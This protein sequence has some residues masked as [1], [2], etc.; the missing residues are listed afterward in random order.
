MWRPRGSGSQ[1][2][3]EFA[4]KRDLDRLMACRGLDALVVFGGTESNPIMF[5][6]TDGANISNGVYIH[7]KGKKPHLVH[8]PMER[9]N[10][11][12]S[13][14]EIS[15]YA[16]HGLAG[17]L[18]KEPDEVS[19]MASFYYSLLRTMGVQGKVS[20]YGRQ[21]LSRLLPVISRLQEI[22]RDIEVVPDTGRTVFDEARTTKS[23]EEIAK[24]RSIGARCE[25]AIARVVE[26]LRT[27][28]AEGRA[29]LDPAGERLTLGKIK[30]VLRDEL[31]SRSLLEATG[32]IV[33]MGAEAGVPHNHGTDSVEV[34]VES[35]IIMDVFPM[36][37]GGGYHFDITRTFC[38]GS[39]PPAVR[40]IYQDV[41]DVQ[42]D[43]IAALKVGE[44]GW[45]YQ[46]LACDIFEK[47]GYPTIRQN[48]KLTEGYVHNLGHGIGLE[49]HES[50][51]L[52]G[53]PTNTDV[54]V[55]GS[56]FTIE[57]GLYFPSKAMAVRLEDVVY[58]KEDGTFENL[59][60]F[61]RELE[62]PVR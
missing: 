10:A 61:P 34:I 14:L 50:P 21:E 52:A 47:K 7:R 23:E 54:I 12:A 55:E 8:N 27:C 26:F 44:R 40:K 18:E 39:A 1:P 46:S 49:V 6:V 48:E 29:V 51:R 62:I 28:K 45:S 33:A 57:P 2:E 15:S 38:L 60:T 31:L 43:C 36:E 56:V 30:K 13:G 11:A 35:P 32:S 59:T 58:A 42:M 41:L 19:A 4:V 17:F 3:R 20:F 37:F 16:D 24:I 25:E 9:D 22:A 5:Y 53:P